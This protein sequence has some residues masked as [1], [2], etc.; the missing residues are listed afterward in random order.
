M[1]SLTAS[2]TLGPTALAVVG[3]DVANQAIDAGQPARAVSILGAALALQPQAAPLHEA[4]GLAFYAQGDIAQALAEFQRAVQL[5]STLASAH[6]N[7]GVTWLALGR[8]A[9]AA[10]TLAEAT[11]LN[12]GLAAAFTN[13]GYARRAG[14]QRE[15][16]LIAFRRAADLDP[17]QM[18][19]RL[20]W[21]A[22]MFEAEAFAAAQAAWR[23]VLRVRPDQPEALAGV[24]AAAVRLGQ[25]AAALQP[26]QASLTQAPE[27][28]TTYF[29]LGLAWQALE[30]PGNARLAFAQAQ[31]FSQDPTLQRLVRARL[32]AL[33]PATGRD[34]GTS[35]VPQ[36]TR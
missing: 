13:L 23:D 21:A 7:L 31:Q 19:A 27:T 34:P 8:P 32:L 15:S 25:P 20:Q 29:Y 2:A 17:Q 16:A 35:L 33:S 30:R 28:A 24:G 14:G 1:R 12:P 10:V 6:N 4:L 22:L 9:A 36:P 18:D 5:D 3:R 26:R 11:Q